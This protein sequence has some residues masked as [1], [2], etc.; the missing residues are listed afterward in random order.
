MKLSVT[1]M[2]HI[3]LSTA[4]LVICALLS[5]PF[6][7]PFSMQTFAI[8]TITALLGPKK[9]FFSLCC[10]LVIGLTGLPVFSGF[11]GGI[12]ILFGAT[13]GYLFGF[14]LTIPI[15]GLL[16]KFFRH[17]KKL[18]LF[19]YFLAMFFGLWACYTFGSLWYLVLYT[20]NLTFSSL[21]SVISL[22]VL[23]FLL[24]DIAKIMLSYYVVRLIKKGLTRNL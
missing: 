13:G 5:I 11:R 18:N 15:T 10:Y 24:P 3:A 22:C 23:P 6:V 4:C 2:V 21:Y 1:D 9:A 20:D 7:I 12:G 19:T 16:L 14:M 8:F 17:H